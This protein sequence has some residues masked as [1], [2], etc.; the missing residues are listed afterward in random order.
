MEGQGL[1]GGG[2]SRD[3]GGGGKNPP[4]WENP[5]NMTKSAHKLIKFAR[6]FN[7]SYHLQHKIIKIFSK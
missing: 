3:G 2:Q 4:T 7:L 5:A 6:S 1:D